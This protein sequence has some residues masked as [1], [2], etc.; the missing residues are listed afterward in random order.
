MD[1]AVDA[2]RYLYE[3]AE[4]GEVAHLGGVARAYRVALFD[5]F[6]RVG[7]ELLDAERHLPLLT[8]EG[9]DNRFHLVAYLHEVLCRT[10]VLV[11]RH[12]RYVD[13]TLYAGCDFD[14]CA[15]VVHHHDLALHHVAHLEVRVE[16]FPRMGREL[17]EAEGDTFLRVVEVEDDHVEFLVELYDLLRMVHAAPA[18]VG[19]MDKSVYAAQV[20]EYAVGGYV[21]DRTF[22]Y[23]TFFELGHD[24]LLLRFELLFDER[25]VRYNHVTELLVDFHHLELHGLVHVHV[26][27]ADGLHVY[28]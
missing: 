23:L 15:V 16:R 3:D 1:E 9:E 21:L 28:L 18:E 10:Q 19:D 8:V 5:T 24:F 22:E 14:E 13:E 17:L 11:P 7:G 4:I 2:V 26:V 25:L 20:D 12:L 6:P 27:V